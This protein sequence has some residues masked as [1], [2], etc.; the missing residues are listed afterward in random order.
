[1]SRRDICQEEPPH[2]GVLSGGFLGW[3]WYIGRHWDIF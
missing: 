2:L 3:D 1:M